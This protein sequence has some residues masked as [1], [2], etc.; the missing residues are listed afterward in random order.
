MPL[1]IIEPMFFYTS[2]QN[3]L[4]PFSSNTETIICQTLCVDAVFAEVTPP[5]PTF[6][7]GYG[8]AILQMD[9]VVLGGIYGLNG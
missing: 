9:M 1:P 2:F 6:T 4:Q 8:N 3:A 5:H 7:D